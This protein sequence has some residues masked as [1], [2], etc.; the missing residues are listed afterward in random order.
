MTAPRDLSR[1][2]PEHRAIVEHIRAL[3]PDES[4]ANLADTIEG[5]SDLPEAIVATLRIALEREVMAKGL[6]DLIEQMTARKRRLEDG[7]KLLRG[8]VLQAIQE[9]GVAMPLRAPD[10]TVSIGRGK[11]RV[12]I[13][14]ADLV[15]ESLCK[16]VRQPDKNL[17]AEALAKGD[18][19]G[20]V[21][22]NP[23]PFISVHRS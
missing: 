6:A 12:V 20:A 7:A 1:L 23:Q 22:G 8:S 13:T 18:V 4:D 21:L 10:M 5:M 9:A 3:Y 11:P 17:I 2:V 16:I 14:D 19:A 15:P